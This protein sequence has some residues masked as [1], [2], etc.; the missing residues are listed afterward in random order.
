[1]FI[2]K[3]LPEPLG[4]NEFMKYI[5]S[6][7]AGDVKARE[8]IIVHNLKLVLRQVLR[9]FANVPY[10]RN[11]LVSVGCIG[12]VKAVDAFDITKEF[13]FST[14]AT[15]CINNEILNFMNKNKKTLEEEHLDRTLYCYGD[16]NEVRLC[17]VIADDE[18]D[19]DLNVI[20]NELL[21]EVRRQVNMLKG[22]DKE[23][24]KMYFGFYDRKYSQKEL[25]DIFNIS[26]TYVSRRL[27]ILIQRIGDKLEVRGLIEPQC[28]STRSK[29]LMKKY[30]K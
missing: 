7:R 17:D 13:D 21:L 4:K 16:G 15:R 29:V 11:E 24:I 12:L 9:E 19:F 14:Y 18:V 3:K 2:E 27:G 5:R 22:R 1:M 28:V 26:Q 8:K 20:N 6:A 30:Y 25:A 10:D 23:M